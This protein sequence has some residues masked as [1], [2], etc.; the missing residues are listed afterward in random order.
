VGKDSLLFKA[1]KLY[2]EI[3]YSEILVTDKNKVNELLQRKINRNPSY[4]FAVV[5]SRFGFIDLKLDDLFDNGFFISDYEKEILNDGIIIGIKNGRQNINSSYIGEGGFGIVTKV[6]LKDGRFVAKKTLKLKGDK[7]EQVSLKRRF[8]REV[9]YQQGYDHPNIVPII[10]LD[11]DGDP[12][13]FTMPLATCNLEKEVSFGKDCSYETKIKAFLNTLDGIDMLHQNGHVHRDIKPQNILRFD[14]PDDSFCY[15]I[16]DFGLISPSDR[17]TTTNITSV[18]DVM[19]TPSYMARECYLEGFKCA[20][21]QSD[22]Y[23]LG[24]LILFLFRER[25]ENLG[26]PYSE[27]LS[28][29]RFGVII[30]KCTKNNPEDRYKSIFQLRA[31]FVDVVGEV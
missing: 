3:L 18:G 19:G 1:A 12:P 14:C 8:K 21:I 11:L 27:R 6:Q 4:F 20:N 24:V 16:S 28:S 30:S 31:A 17:S 15:A 25:D 22:I 2:G 23:S 13:S 29:G 26:V 10:D 9:Q 5:K 7:Y